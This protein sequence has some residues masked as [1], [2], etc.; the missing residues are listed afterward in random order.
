LAK[1]QILHKWIQGNQVILTVLCNYDK[2]N[3]KVQCSCP[4][5]M[6]RNK[7]Q[8]EAF[9]REVYEAN[10]PKKVS[11]KHIPKEVDW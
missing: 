3:K 8:F 7:E 9:L 2:S 1:V 11:L 4:I 10:K 6:T 5:E